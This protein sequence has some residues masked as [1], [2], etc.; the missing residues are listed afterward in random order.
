M[1]GDT[2]GFPLFVQGGV[3]KRGI[4]ERSGGTRV[5]F[6]ATPQYLGFQPCFI[7]ASSS[8]YGYFLF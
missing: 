7:Y 5:F 8:D 3:N 1:S 6:G 4:G 2:K